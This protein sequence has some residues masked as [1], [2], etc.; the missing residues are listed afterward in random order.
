MPELFKGA[1]RK[2][3]TLNMYLYLLDCKLLPEVY[4][5]RPART[6]T[7]AGKHYEKGE[8]KGT[9]TCKGCKIDL[10]L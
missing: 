10:I 2:D 1:M 7:R 8:L 4:K 9:C 5:Y 3:K 6:T